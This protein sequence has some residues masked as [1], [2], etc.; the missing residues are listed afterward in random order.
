[1]EK[2]KI[3]GIITEGITEP[4]NNGTPGSA[5]YAIPFRLNRTPSSLWAEIFVKTWDSPPQF[6]TSHRP[7]IARIS[8]DTIILDGTTIDE[9]KRTHRKTLELCI[10]EANKIEAEI[11]QEEKAKNEAAKKRSSE[12]RKTI[13]EQVKDIKLD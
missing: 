11:L 12:F 10:S 2:I 8:G 13:D 4:R 5:L 3:V 6:T 9:V 7:R 1:M